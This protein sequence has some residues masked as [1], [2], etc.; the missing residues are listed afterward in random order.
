MAPMDAVSPKDLP[1][2]YGR[3]WHEDT[4]GIV[5]DVMAMII[6]QMKRKYSPH[7][8]WPVI[9]DMIRDPINADDADLLAN[10]FVGLDDSESYDAKWDVLNAIA[11]NDSLPNQLRRD[12]IEPLQHLT[13]GTFDDDG[14]RERVVDNLAQRIYNLKG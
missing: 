12:V 2:I 7:T 10:L 5:M 14:D 6:E 11:Q 13:V 1:A 3:L 4:I 9:G 8:I